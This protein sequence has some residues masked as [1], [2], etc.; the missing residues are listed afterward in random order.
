[1]SHEYFNT[2]TKVFFSVQS[3]SEFRKDLILATPHKWYTILTLD[4]ANGEMTI[5]DSNID[6]ALKFSDLVEKKFK[7][8][9]IVGTS[10]S[11]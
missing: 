11:F 3:I 10:H 5:D 1:M 2:K 7:L 4:H 9:I 6:F 8:N